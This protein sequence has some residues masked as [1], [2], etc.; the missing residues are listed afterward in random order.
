MN[1]MWLEPWTPIAQP[2]EREAMQSQLGSELS[3]SHALFGLSVVALARRH[4]QDDV[5]FE[6]ADGRV[7]E[8]HL[9]W[10]HKTET[11]PRWP[12][13]TIFASAAVWAEERMKRLHEEA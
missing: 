13:A 7:A 4:D 2:G 6:L 8:V 11:N 9:T 3:T 1:M 10:S 12:R 5:L